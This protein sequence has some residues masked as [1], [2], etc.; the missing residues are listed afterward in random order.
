MAAN[1]GT[2]DD[3]VRRFKFRTTPKTGFTPAQ[4]EAALQRGQ[5]ALHQDD[6]NDIV[7]DTADDEV[8]EPE[9]ENGVDW[10]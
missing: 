6:A 1:E 3:V 7:D 8:V 2:H 9:V 10:L 5:D 4:R